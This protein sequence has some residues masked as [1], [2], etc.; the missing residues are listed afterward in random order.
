VA[1]PTK[2]RGKESCDRLR[3]E[4]AQ[5]LS[6]EACCGLLGVSKETGY[7]WSKRFP[8]FADAKRDG[9]TLGQVYWEK[10]GLENLT[11]CPEAVKFN[12]TVWVFTMK[13]RFGWRDKRELTGPGG[14]PLLFA[15]LST[16]QID[17]K[18]DELLARMPPEALLKA[19][20]K[21]K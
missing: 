5:G 10:K 11:T 1:K 16:A 2:Y 7:Q 15:D 19:L 4:M 12:A 17:S 6:F 3:D 21:R 9:E 13:N 14:G 20:G 18:L 8:D